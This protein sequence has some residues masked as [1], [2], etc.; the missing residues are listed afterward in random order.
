MNKQHKKINTEWL[1]HSIDTVYF[2]SRETGHHVRNE[3]G[4]QDA[5][6]PFHADT[7]PSLRVLIP[8]GAFSCLACGASGGDVITF[9]MKNYG[10]DFLSAAGY[11]QREYGDAA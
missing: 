2:Y 8:E 4:W 9:T 10:I 7:H 5:L 11:L 6:C 1:K 3:N